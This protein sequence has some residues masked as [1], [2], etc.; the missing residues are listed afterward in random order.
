MLMALSTQTVKGRSLSNTLRDF[1]E[2]TSV[3]ERIDSGFD[4]LPLLLVLGPWNDRR[5]VNTA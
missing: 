1:K 3:P 4:A 2:T 5:A